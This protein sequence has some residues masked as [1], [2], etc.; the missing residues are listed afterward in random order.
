[1]AATVNCYICDELIWRDE[2]GSFEEVENYEV[3]YQCKKCS[4]IATNHRI[5][6]IPFKSFFLLL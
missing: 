5:V 3:N 4:K 6:D 1:M 2:K